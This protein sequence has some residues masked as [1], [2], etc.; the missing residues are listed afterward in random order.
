MACGLYTEEG[1][2]TQIVRLGV[3]DAINE[4]DRK[5]QH[6][7][8]LCT[9]C[10]TGWSE[11]RI[12]E[13]DIEVPGHFMS[14]KLHPGEIFPIIWRGYD[15]DDD[16]IGDEDDNEDDDEDD[17]VSPATVA[18]PY[19][20]QVGLPPELTN[21][22][23]A[24]CDRIGITDELRKLTGENPLPVEENIVHKFHLMAD[25]KDWYVQRPPLKWTSNMHWIS[26][27]DES[28]HEEYLRVLKRGN[29]DIVLDA[30]GKHLGLVSL[31]AYHLTFIGV[32]YS[33]KGFIHY[34]SIN[35]GAS[36]YNIIIPLI[37][38]DDATPELALVVD[39]D[40]DRPRRHGALKYKLG[41]AAMMGDEAYH[42]TEACDYRESKGMRLAA[43]VYIADISEKNA[44]NIARQTLTQIFP[45]ADAKWL[46]AE[47]GRH[48]VADNYH[49]KEDL[50]QNKGR[51]YFE[52]SDLLPDCA[53]R[54]NEGKCISDIKVTRAKCLRSCG[55]YEPNI[56][57]F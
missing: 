21:E 46:I 17:D 30:I 53:A 34:D 4:D 8:E 41:T 29:F 55:I 2:T 38:E 3:R 35:T 14:P 5:Q 18:T 43:T 11:C 25:G 52:F 31:V 23:L 1:L 36:V 13:D 33:E 22:L 28:T 42:G 6:S 19:A 24:Y 48:W 40:G 56:S 7:I 54:A 16:G 44:E 15:D 9:R 57:T 37:L 20:F 26:P 27:A 49:G 47:A 12:Y 51:E 50:P 45:L 32:S 39:E 10:R